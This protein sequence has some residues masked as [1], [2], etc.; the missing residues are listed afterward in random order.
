MK[1]TVKDFLGQRDRTVWTI[2]ADSTV[3]DALV[4]MSKKGIGALVVLENGKV[5]GI[6]SER[7]YAR[8]VVL[9]GKSSKESTVNELMTREITFVR[10]ENTIEECMTL[11]SK[12]HIRHL[13]VLEGDELI[14]VITI[15]DV[16]KKVIEDQQ[17]TIQNL[18]DY[19]YGR[20]YG[21]QSYI[22]D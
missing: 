22:K 1:S 4:K 6:F 12:K 17:L 8:K 16:L 9:H 20:A 21:A 13:P 3:Y 14:G 10:P 7:D 11:L 18:E 19:I 2:D 15:R 5:A